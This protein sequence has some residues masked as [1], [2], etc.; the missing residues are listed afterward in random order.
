MGDAFASIS[1]K[2]RVVMAENRYGCRVTKG[3]AG[4]WEWRSLKTMVM[5]AWPRAASAFLAGDALG[6]QI[7]QESRGFRC[8]PFTM[9]SPRSSPRTRPRPGVG[10]DLFLVGLE[11]RRGA[12]LEG[13]GLGGDHVHQRAA[14]Q[15]GE[16]GGIDRLSCSAFIRMMPP[17]GRAGSCGWSR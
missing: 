10:D 8:G 2:P 14:L 11:P 15:P 9:R 16:D 12:F 1:V 13:H 6:P 17:R 4:R 5:W 7:H 3:F